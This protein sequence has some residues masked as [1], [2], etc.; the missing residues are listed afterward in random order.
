M[1]PK[2]ASTIDEQ[3]ADCDDVNAL[4]TR[5]PS[6]ERGMGEPCSCLVSVGVDLHGTFVVRLFQPLLGRASLN[7]Q[8]IVVVPR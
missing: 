4:L 7:A 3:L 6:N 5:P 8:Y 1:A 2:D